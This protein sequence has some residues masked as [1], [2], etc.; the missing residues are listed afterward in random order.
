MF[1]CYTNQDFSTTPL[2]HFRRGTQPTT[3][4]LGR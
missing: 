1:I 3:Q 4:I 2:A